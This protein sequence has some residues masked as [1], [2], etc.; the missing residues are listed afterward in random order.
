MQTIGGKCADLQKAALIDRY[1]GNIKGFHEEGRRN[2][3]ADADYDEAKCT[4]RIVHKGPGPPM[5][6]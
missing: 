6:G 5:D 1:K 2:W 3:M 4:I